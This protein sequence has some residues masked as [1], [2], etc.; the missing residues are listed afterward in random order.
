M[1]PLTSAV[2]HYDAM[3]VDHCELTSRRAAELY[4]RRKVPGTTADDAAVFLADAL[5]CRAHRKLAGLEHSK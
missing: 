2:T 3:R 4:L 1:S 5:A